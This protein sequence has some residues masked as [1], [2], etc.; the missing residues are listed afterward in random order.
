MI[1]A[2]DAYLKLKST[3]D[4]LE[5]ITPNKLKVYPRKI[6]ILINS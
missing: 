6:L 4:A 2:G 1:Y 3:K 5:K